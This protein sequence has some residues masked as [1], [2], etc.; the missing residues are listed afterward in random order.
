MLLLLPRDVL[1]LPPRDAELLPRAE[2]VLLL[3]SVSRVSS[4]FVLRPAECG[5]VLVFAMDNNIA[6]F[7]PREIIVS[8]ALNSSAINKGLLQCVMQ[9]QLQLCP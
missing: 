1:T 9:H 8:L 5:D 3:R 4:D 7:E 2:R 6:L